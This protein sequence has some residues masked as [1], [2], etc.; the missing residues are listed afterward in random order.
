MPLIFKRQDDTLFR[1]GDLK[2]VWHARSPKAPAMR[3]AGHARHARLTRGRA[4]FLIEDDACRSYPRKAKE[5]GT[6]A[7]HD[8]FSAIGTE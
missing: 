6:G 8:L 7:I 2:R 1:R 4:I 5:C 3:G